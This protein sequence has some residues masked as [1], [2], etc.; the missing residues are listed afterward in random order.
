MYYIKNMLDKLHKL[1]KLKKIKKIVRDIQ[2]GDELFI[3]SDYKVE[4]RN[5]DMVYQQDQNIWE[6]LPR[7]FATI[8]V[9]NKNNKTKADELLRVVSGLRKFGAE[10]DFSTELNKN[11]EILGEVYLNK[12]NGEYFSVSSFERKNQVYFVLRSKNVSII[13]R[14]NNFLDDLKIYNE[15]RYEYVLQMANTFYN[16]YF[17]L[18]DKQKHEI[19]KKCNVHTINFE[20]C[21][22]KY[23]HLVKYDNN[24]SIYPFA[25]TQYTAST[26]GLVSELPDISQK[27]FKQVGLGEMPYM[28]T[29]YKRDTN[30]DF[31]KKR[32]EIRSKIYNEEN[33]EGSVVYVIAHDKITGKKRVKEIYKFKNYNYVFWRALREKMRGRSSI[34]RTVRRLRNLHCSVPDLNGMIQEGLEFYA[35][36]WKIIDKKKWLELFSKWVDVYNEFKTIDTEI[37]L[38]YFEE[39]NELNKKNSQI[40][41]FPIGIPGLGKSTLLKTIEKLLPNAIRVNQDECH[42]SPKLYHKNIRKFSNDKS[43]KYLLLDKCNHNLAV[44]Q[45]AYD[46]MNLQKVVYIIFYHPK[47][48]GN[49]NPL[50]NNT[51]NNLCL[52]NAILTAKQRI[53]M[54]GSGHLNLYPSQKLRNI[55]AGFKDSYQS[56]TEE[57]IDSASAIIPIDI[58]LNPTDMIIAFLSSLVRR[59]IIN[60]YNEDKI[61]EIYGQVAKEESELAKKNGSKFKT[62]YWGVFVDEIDRILNLGLVNKELKKNKHLAPKIDELHCTMLFVKNGV[63]ETPYKEYENKKVDLIITHVAYDKKIMALRVNPTFPCDNKHP[64]IT[65]A[66]AKGVRPV[67][68][69]QMLENPIEDIKLFKPFVIKGTVI[70]II[71]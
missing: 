36:C 49:Q 43:Y 28:H 34:E 5:D 30:Y 39:F 25:L 42:G 64:H 12:A 69:N 47:D 16:K 48:I 40:Q 14:D 8:Y 59:N 65:L 61:P 31:S 2:L 53:N 18:S 63:D 4:G 9:L 50:N 62:L 15:I 46:G 7:C 27:W 29:I 45:A 57:E 70:R 13:V 54:R 32:A 21:S 17:S 37:R 33:S 11:E 23:Q 35:Y 22:K 52:D 71:K 19:I 38:K 6:L 10:G 44:R 60:K 51:F 41:I 1:N 68:S 24:E 26:N 58:T 20:W 56:L 55:L 67:Y 3:V 66:L